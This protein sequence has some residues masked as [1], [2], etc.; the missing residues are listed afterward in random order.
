MLKNRAAHLEDVLDADLSGVLEFE[1]MTHCCTAW[2]EVSKCSPGFVL[3]DLWKSFPTSTI[4]ITGISIYIYIH[5]IYTHNNIYIY[6]CVWI[7]WVILQ[8]PPSVAFC[9]AEICQKPRKRCR[10]VA[11]TPFGGL[12]CLLSCIFLWRLLYDLEQTRYLLR[13]F[14]HL[15]VHLVRGFLS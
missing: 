6:V 10:K 4:K 9:P 1:E 3:G 11:F 5:Y 14:S 13:W 7:K 15:D 2:L 8:G 12:D